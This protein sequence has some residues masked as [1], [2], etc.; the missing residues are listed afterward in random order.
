[1]SRPKLEVADVFRKYGESFLQKYGAATSPEQRRV[2]HAIE[3]CRTESLGGHVDSCDDCGHQV[4]SYNSCRNRHC[5][6]CQSLAKAK[7][8]EDRQSEVL[9]VEYYHVVFTMPDSLA[10]IALQN[11]QV[12]YNILFKTAAKTLLT[13]AADPKHLGAKIGFA[14]ILHTWGQ[15]LMHHP[16]LHCVVPGGGLAAHEEKWISCRSG[17]FLPVKVLS[18]LFRRLFLD[19]LKQAFQNGE[20]D[21]YGKNQPLANPPA[22]YRLIAA[23]R[24]MEWV[25]YAKPPFGGPERV[26]NYLAR[27]THR[28]AISNHRLVSMKDGKVTFNLKNYKNAGKKETLT[29]DAEEFIRRFL[30]HVLP[31][32]FMKIRYYGFLA[33]CHR[34]EKIQLCR[35]LL[36]CHEMVMDEKNDPQDWAER[37]K[38]LTGKDPFQCPKCGHGRLIRIQTLPP[39]K[40]DQSR[41]PPGVYS[42]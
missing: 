7:W 39:L 19:S 2:M 8:L 23:C 16:H 34:T 31:N 6:K 37:F 38:A 18:R 27:Y 21:F 35:R 13:I 41:S 28:I 20:L 12:V 15:N 11:K 30:L 26:L 22:F 1:M 10:A 36:D 9:P 42:L 17:F 4:I 24:E 40:F 25:V 14:A 33:N 5:P 32:Q 3:I 29:L